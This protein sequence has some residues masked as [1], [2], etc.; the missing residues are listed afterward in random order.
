MNVQVGQLTRPTFACRQLFE[1]CEMR[2][3]T[4]RLRPIR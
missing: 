4:Y 3:S 1:N 2:N